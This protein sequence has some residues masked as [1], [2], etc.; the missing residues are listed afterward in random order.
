MNTD[1]KRDEIRRQKNKPWYVK[2][3]WFE[4]ELAKALGEIDMLEDTAIAAAYMASGINIDKTSYR[5][6]VRDFEAKIEQRTKEACYEVAW[7]LLLR[8]PVSTGLYEPLKRDLKQAIDS[9]GGTGG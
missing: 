3:P 6:Q 1:D 7:P 4:K 2:C 5:Q 9:V 8:I